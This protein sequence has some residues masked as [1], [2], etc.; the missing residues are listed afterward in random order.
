MPDIPF[1]FSMGIE[2]II[3][4]KKFPP[5]SC[6]ANSGSIKPSSY[7]FFI[8]VGKSVKACV[9]YSVSKSF[10]LYQGQYMACYSTI[11]NAIKKLINSLPLS[12]VMGI[13]SS[14]SRYH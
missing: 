14:L 11:P 6:D 1:L 9:I 7:H 13:S 2:F 5:L 4:A 8:V 10:F 3:A 12:S